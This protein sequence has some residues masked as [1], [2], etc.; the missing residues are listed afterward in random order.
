M[1]SLPA[2]VY[3][4]LMG[5]YRFFQGADR[6]EVVVDQR[7]W[8]SKPPI[9]FG[10]YKTV[11]TKTPECTA[12]TLFSDENPKHHIIYL[13]GGAYVYKARVPHWYGIGYFLKHLSCSVSFVDY[14]LAP[15]FTC[16]ATVPASLEIYQRLSK[17][18]QAPITLMG[19]SAGGGLSLV[20]SEMI[21]KKNI[22]PAPERVVL[23]SPWLDV[24]VDEGI[25]PAQEKVDKMLTVEG[26]RRAGQAYSGNRNVK[27][28]LCSPLFGDLSGLPDTAIFTGTHDLIYTDSLRLHK[29]MT[30]LSVN[31]VYYEYPEMQHAFMLAPMP[32]GT[33]ALKKACAFV[34]ASTRLN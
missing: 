19:D 8:F 12:Y 6:R 25:T 26:L 15:A 16:E 11:K 13:H 10:Q 18:S 33:D 2:S 20:L 5:I 21:N 23:F 4:I 34:T 30:E 29:K 17:L 27:D 14:P 24:A 28:P 31:H 3:E 1:K 22:I 7:E 32:E 9:G